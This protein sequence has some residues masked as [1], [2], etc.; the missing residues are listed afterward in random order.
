MKQEALPVG[1]RVRINCEPACPEE[2]KSHAIRPYANKQTGVVAKV[3]L[4]LGDHNYVIILDEPVRQ[5]GWMT[6]HFAY[7]KRT[8]LE[9]VDLSEMM[10]ISKED[11][12]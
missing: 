10:G 7:F 4:R 6:Q 5:K 8:E 1:T 2:S 12:G 9:P 11:K 3:D